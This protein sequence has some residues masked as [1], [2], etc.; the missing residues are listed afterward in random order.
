MPLAREE[1]GAVHTAGFDADEDAPGGRGW[2]GDVLE[3]EDFGSAGVV[4]DGCAHYFGHGG[5]E[6]LERGCCCLLVW[7]EKES[8][9]SIEVVGG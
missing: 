5:E 9:G 8:S 1:L 4:H 7:D 2:D 3:L 6:A